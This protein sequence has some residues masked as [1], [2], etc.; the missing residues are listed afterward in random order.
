MFLSAPTP[1]LGLERS[2]KVMLGTDGYSWWTFRNLLW[3]WVK[4]W[5]LAFI[6]GTS[7][8]GGSGH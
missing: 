7:P 8:R 3:L 2:D 1:N 5:G 4:G 6:S